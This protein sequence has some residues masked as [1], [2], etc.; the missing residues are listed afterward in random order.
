[1]I[2]N[3]LVAPKKI[4]LITWWIEYQVAVGWPWLLGELVLNASNYL[5]RGTHS[6]LVNLLAIPWWFIFGKVV[7]ISRRNPKFPIF[8]VP[9]ILD[10][11]NLLFLWLV[12]TPF[13]YEGIL[14]N[15]YKHEKRGNL[16]MWI[17]CNQCWKHAMI[18]YPKIIIKEQYLKPN[19]PLC[20]HSYKYADNYVIVVFATNIRKN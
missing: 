12:K 7:T 18:W 17:Q 13:L 20:V 3:R 1:M 11:N 8:R 16:H 6:Y 14:M 19:Y 9:F 15:I 4:S 2:Q 5:V 10:I